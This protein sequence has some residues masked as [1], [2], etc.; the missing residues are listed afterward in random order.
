MDHKKALLFVSILLFGAACF[1][2]GALFGQHLLMSNGYVYGSAQT[3]A[4]PLT[5]TSSAA[6]ATAE[7]DA[8]E[9]VAAAGA[10]PVVNINTATY[11]ELLTV[12][13][14]GEVTANKILAARDEVGVF[15]DTYDLV[16]C[17]VMGDAKY[18]H[19]KIYLT[20]E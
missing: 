5:D 7:M 1:G 4:E 12:N 16:T 8:E 20:V 19:L 17:G 6:A 18:N 10:D 3:Q 14:I 2:G 9:E 15:Q 13:G 11:E